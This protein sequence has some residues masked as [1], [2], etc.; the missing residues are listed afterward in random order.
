MTYVAIGPKAWGTSKVSALAAVKECKKHVPRSILYKG[1][2]P[3]NVF[4]VEDFVGV[5]GLGRI[6]YK[7]AK[8][9]AIEPSF[10]L[11]TK[12]NCWPR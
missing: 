4:T 5:D 2:Y 6:E 1:R 12:A 9:V 3:I 11:V 7:G 8:P 10:V